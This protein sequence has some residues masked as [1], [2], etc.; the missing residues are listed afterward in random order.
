[1]GPFVMAW[2]VGEGIIIY[3][4]VKT[5]KAPPGPGQ[6]MWS[7]GLFL[8]LSLIAET[9]SGRRPATLMAWGVNLAA[10]MNLF[11]S[12]P[13]AVGKA[14]GQV[15]KDVVSG[16]T[17]QWPPPIAVNTTVIPSGTSADTASTSGSGGSGS[18]L[19]GFT[20]NLTE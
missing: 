14:L 3:R 16:T 11:P 19:K 5:Y 8:L 6:L 15:G 17:A 10:F 9:D 7:S 12:A 13:S 1:M 2:L 4:T 18:A 20:P